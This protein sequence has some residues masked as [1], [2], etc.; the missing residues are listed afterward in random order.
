M[1]RPKTPRIKRRK[2]VRKEDSIRIRVTAE[3]KEILNVAAER[4]GQG[5]SSWLLAAGLRAARSA[6]T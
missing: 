2:E 5:L 4:D 1:A 6:S 3:Q